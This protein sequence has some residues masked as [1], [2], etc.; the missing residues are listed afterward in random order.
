MKL[1][2]DAKRVSTWLLRSGLMNQIHGKPLVVLLT[3][4]SSGEKISNEPIGKIS[5][6][7]KAGTDTNQVVDSMVEF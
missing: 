3:I 2:D 7:V 5:I 4:H 6:I 1:Q